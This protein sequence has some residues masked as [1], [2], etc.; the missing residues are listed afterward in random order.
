MK[1]LKKHKYTNNIMH[2][3][4]CFDQGAENMANQKASPDYIL[5]HPKSALKRMMEQ[6]T[7]PA[8]RTETTKKEAL[9]KK[10]KEFKALGDT[11]AAHG[12]A[13]DAL[14]EYINDKEITK[15]YESIDKWYA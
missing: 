5:V 3:P 11:E 1:Q 6:F 7:S 13:D 9:L 15:A 2:C 10:L 12:Y 4:D 14:I 8:E